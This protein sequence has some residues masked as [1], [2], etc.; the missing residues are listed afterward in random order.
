ML[1]ADCERSPA[2][3]FHLGSYPRLTRQKERTILLSV[4]IRA[5]NVI[6]ATVLLA[7]LTSFSHSASAQ[8]S[9]DPGTGES[10]FL[11]FGAGVFDIN[12]DWASAAVQVEYASKERFWIFHPIAGVMANSDM[13]GDAYVGVG[14]DL[15]VGD[16]WVVT[17]SFAPSLYWR[18]SSKNLGETLEFRSSIGV[19]YRFD[20]HSRLGLELYHLSN[21]GLDDHNPGTA[22]LLAKYAVPFSKIAGGL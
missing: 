14:V 5:T 7:V 9:L 16:R 2:N 12:D 3:S 8:V 20:D 22:V 4:R 11:S 19:A 1:R 13:G 10:D 21:A 15:F 17:P 6:A 18:G